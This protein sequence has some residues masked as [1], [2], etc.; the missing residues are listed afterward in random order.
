M[1][2]KHPFEEDISMSDSPDFVAHFSDLPDPRIERAKRH[3]LVDI[4]FIAVCTIICGGESFTDMEL[5]GKS[6]EV[7]LRQLLTLPHGIPSHDTFGRVFSLLNPQAFGESFLRWTAALHEATQ[8]EVIALDGKTVRHSFDAATGQG[9]LHLI[10]AWASKS[11][12]TLGQ[13]KVEGKSNEIT[14][15]PTLLKLLDVTG[16][17][18]TMDAM[19]CQKELA[20]QI[21][22][23]GGDY[24]LGLKGNQGHLHEEVKYFFDEAQRRQFHDVPH[25]YHATVEKAH[26][27]IEMRRCWLVTEVA[28]EWL[29]RQNQ[30]PGMASIAALEA[31]RRIGRKVTKET[32]YFIST[33][34]SSAKQLMEAART[35]W[36]IENSLHWVLDVTL[37]EDQSRIRKEHAPENLALLRRLALNLIR[38]AKP[39]KASVR[40]SIKKAGWD[41]SFLEKILVS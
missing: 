10:S 21:V 40:G 27:R 13:Q 8:G 39:P 3:L 36:K 30:W 2:R 32:R 23:Q 31:E 25:D 34:Q 4:L 22:E 41:N 20:G 5:F 35:H 18:V 7:W 24:V 26:G 15:L 11:G 1:D 37:H 17:I 12:V 16:C 29:E 9:A 19:G 38:K 6:K 33:L 14:A 28:M